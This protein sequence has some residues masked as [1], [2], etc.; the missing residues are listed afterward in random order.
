MYC[1][2]INIQW[3]QITHVYLLT[4]PGIRVALFVTGRH[5]IFL[6]QKCGCAERGSFIYIMNLLIQKFVQC[7]FFVPKAGLNLT[8]LTLYST[9]VSIPCC[10][11]SN[12]HVV[13]FGGW[14]I[15]ILVNM[16]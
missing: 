8:T 6:V 2:Y 14:A 7:V 10:W 16:L 3:K 15:L 9:Q 1:I 13:L 11:P 12:A 5:K 4:K